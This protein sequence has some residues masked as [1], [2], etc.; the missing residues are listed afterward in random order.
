[1]LKRHVEHNV[2][3][4]AGNAEASCRTQCNGGGQQC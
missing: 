3:E 2:M 1:M 4:E